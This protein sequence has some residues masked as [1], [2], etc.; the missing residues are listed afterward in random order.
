MLLQNLPH[1]A[2]MIHRGIEVK[3]ID[4][5]LNMKLDLVGTGKNRFY[6]TLAT[7]I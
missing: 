2:N 6:I 4:D 1:T 5:L 3:T 7:L